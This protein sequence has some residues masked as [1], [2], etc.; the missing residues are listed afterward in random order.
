MAKKEKKLLKNVVGKYY[1][2]DNCSG[3]ELC[4]ITNPDNFKMDHDEVHAYVFKQPDKVEE[5]NL[6]QEA[7]NDCPSDAIGDDGE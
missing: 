7:M 5:K 2:D 6:C 1:V 4:T 3:C